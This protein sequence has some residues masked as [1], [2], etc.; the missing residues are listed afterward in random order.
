[1]KIKILSITKLTTNDPAEIKKVIARQ[2]NLRAQA[3]WKANN[4]AKIAEYSANYFQENKETIYEKRREYEEETG[5]SAEYMQTMTTC[6]CGLEDT[7]Q[8]IMNHKKTCDMHFNCKR[9]E[10][11]Y[12]TQPTKMFD[13]NGFCKCP[14]GWS[15]NQK[16]VRF[17]MVYKI[18]ENGKVEKIPKH[19]KNQIFC[20]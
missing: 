18:G 12:E 15:M 7:R 11:M 10:L 20:K 8:N 3:R 4:K 17:H 13:E 19:L 16:V 14:W 9:M 2:K 5:H 1:M 6:R